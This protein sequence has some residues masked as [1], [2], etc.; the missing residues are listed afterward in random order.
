MTAIDKLKEVSAFLKS[1]GIDD[2][3]KESEIIVTHYLGPILN[4]FLP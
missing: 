2:A 4:D 3:N 1:H